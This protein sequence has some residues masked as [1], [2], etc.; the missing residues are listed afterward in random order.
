[1]SLI[2]CTPG[3][4]TDNCYVTLAQADAYY[5]NTL[6]GTDWKQHGADA[7]EQALIQA[8]RRIEQLG[9]TPMDPDSPRRPLF[10][11]GPYD[12]NVQVLHF[13]RTQDRTDA[14]VLTVPQAL[15]DAVCEQALWLLEQRASPDLIDRRKLQE[16]GVA[17]ISMDGHS[18]TYRGSRIPRDIAPAAW[19]LCQQFLQRTRKTVVR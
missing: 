3:G 12:S 5:A 13:P 7:R 11:G 4:A 6:R 2:T 16:Q 18:E 9:G 10:A 19:D 17:T 8:T 1:M 15:R 14:G